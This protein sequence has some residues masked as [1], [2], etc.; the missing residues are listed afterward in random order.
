MSE[1]NSKKKKNTQPFLAPILF[2]VLL[3]AILSFV[4]AYLN[5]T[6]YDVIREQEELAVQKSI[7]Y[8]LGVSYDSEEELQQLIEKNL[9]M[10]ESKDSHYYE[11]KEDETTVGYAFPLDGK[12]LWG[13]VEGYGAVDSKVSTLLGVD[14]VKHSETPGL[15]GRIS[16]DWYKDQFRGI[17]ISGEAPYVSYRPAADGNVDAITGATLTSDSIREIVN[18]G[19]DRFKAEF[20]EVTP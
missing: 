2:M 18:S 1:T 3:S 7:L 10:V 20:Q 13:S 15:G 14:F 9:K 19:I 17:D 11:Y 16:E 4:L 5:Q 12:A 6:T 8:A